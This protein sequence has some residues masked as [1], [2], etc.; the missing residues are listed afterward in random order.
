MDREGNSQ[1]KVGEKWIY[2]I[3]EDK[4]NFLI[5]T[6]IKRLRFTCFL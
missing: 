1:P 5:L 4:G 6:L 3:K 2:K